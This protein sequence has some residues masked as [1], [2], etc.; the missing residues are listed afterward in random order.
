MVGVLGASSEMRGFFAAL[1]M[2]DGGRGTAV[3]NGGQTVAMGTAPWMEVA[4]S[5]I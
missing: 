2:T 4:C 1:R 3:D 5:G